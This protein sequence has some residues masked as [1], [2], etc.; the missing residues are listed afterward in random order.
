MEKLEAFKNRQHEKIVPKIMT[1]LVATTTF[2]SVSIHI[3]SMTC[4]FALYKVFCHTYTARNGIIKKYEKI[5]MSC[6]VW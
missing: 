3:D 2:F 1:T 4:N 6:P 5:S